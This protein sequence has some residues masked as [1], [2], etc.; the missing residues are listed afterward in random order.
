MC[1]VCQVGGVGKISFRFFEC[2]QLLTAPYYPGILGLGVLFLNGPYYPRLIFCKYL[3]I[4]V[5]KI[6]VKT[7]LRHVQLIVLAGL[8][9]IISLFCFSKSK[10]VHFFYIYIFFFEFIFFYICN[11]WPKFRPV[12]II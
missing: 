7:S 8:A 6:G 12:K 9:A 3:C 10:I 11:I 2:L 5:I 4:K 1:R